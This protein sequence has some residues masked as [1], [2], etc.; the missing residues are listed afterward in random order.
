M[1]TEARL[2]PYNKFMEAVTK[3]IQ[4]PTGIDPLDFATKDVRNATH[5][6]KFNPVVGNDEA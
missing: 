4:L 6:R 2:G 1:N 5:R 3:L